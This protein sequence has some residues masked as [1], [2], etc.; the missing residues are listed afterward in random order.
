MDAELVSV[1]PG[2]REWSQMNK[3][4]NQKKFWFLL[5]GGKKC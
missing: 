1:T 4:T 3:L 5:S 2:E